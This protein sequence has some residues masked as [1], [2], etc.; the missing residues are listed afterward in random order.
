MRETIAHTLPS[1]VGLTG[2]EL[3]SQ[4][5]WSHEFCIM[6]VL[7]HL[8]SRV[9]HTSK[10]FLIINLV[11]RYSVIDPASQMDMDKHEGYPGLLLSS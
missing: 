8:I 3:G 6:I 1:V 2:T 4:R 11:G 10:I 5:A 9:F 7:F